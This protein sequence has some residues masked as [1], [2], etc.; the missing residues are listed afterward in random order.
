MTILGF[1][2][3]RPML[4]LFGASAEVLPYAES[5]TGVLLFGT[6]FQ[7]LGFSL[8]NTIRG[9]GKPKIAMLTIASSAVLN[10]ILNPIFIFGLHF[11]IKG[12]ALATVLAQFITA[13]L[14]LGFYFSKHSIIKIRLH[15]LKLKKEYILGIFSIGVS[16]F[17][18]QI[19]SSAIIMIFN[20]ELAYYGGDL[21]IA[22]MGI[23]FAINGLFMMPI[24]GINQGIQPIIGYNFGAQHFH[25][26][27]ETLKIGLTAATSIS[28]LGFITVMFFSNQI[29][30]IF[31]NNNQQ[32]MH[33]GSHGL[34]IVLLM[35]PLLGLQMIGT[36]YFMAVGK[37]KQS[38][39]LTLS[40]QVILLIPLLLILPK[41]FNL[42]GIWMSQP[43]S[44]ILSA[45]LVTI[46]LLH[47]LK[48]LNEKQLQ[49]DAVLVLD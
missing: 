31:C 23:G 46:F 14:V 35:F 24:I 18:M 13:F 38:I 42:D 40:R 2:F 12:S 25:R 33:I 27:K 6:I 32:L 5:Y 3:M 17:A 30:S 29:I 28:L 43:I 36:S 10:A 47:E 49:K 16:P 19:A 4:T 15:N 21:A 37:A 26:V 22:A 39:I 41:F 8:N 44:D 34:R 20:R 7:S 45:T 1:I 9:Q 11:G 48:H